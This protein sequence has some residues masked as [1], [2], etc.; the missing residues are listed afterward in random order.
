VPAGEPVAVAV[1]DAVA[2]AVRVATG[3]TEMDSVLEGDA[4]CVRLP[5]GEAERVTEGVPLVDGV[6]A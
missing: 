6:A 4:P 2:L 3:V 1:P 5:V